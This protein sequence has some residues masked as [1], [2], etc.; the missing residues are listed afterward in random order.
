MRERVGGDCPGS[1]YEGYAV[2]CKDP[3][4]DGDGAAADDDSI[5]ARLYADQS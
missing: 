5:G 3:V 1:A 4:D 2:G